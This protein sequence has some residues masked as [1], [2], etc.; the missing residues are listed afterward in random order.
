MSVSIVLMQNNNFADFFLFIAS[1][2]ELVFTSNLFYY[3]RERW[4]MLPKNER[5]GSSWRSYGGIG[6]PPQKGKY[7]RKS[8]L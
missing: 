6:P 2:I 3:F 1:E 8:N 5:G 7:E 4:K